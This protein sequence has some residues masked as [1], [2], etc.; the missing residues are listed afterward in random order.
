MTYIWERG[1]QEPLPPQAAEIGLP[2][3][4]RPPK[5]S[6]SVQTCAGFPRARRKVLGSR[7]PAPAS[8]GRRRPPV[9]APGVITVPASRACTDS[10]RTTRA[11]ESSLQFQRLSR[12]SPAFVSGSPQARWSKGRANSFPGG[13]PLTGAGTRA[14]GAAQAR[15]LSPARRTRGAARPSGIAPHPGAGLA[16]GG[17]PAQRPSSRA[18]R[19]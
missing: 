11:P 7:S 4:P 13:R 15:A 9:R 1:P 5:R 17:A 8:A 14:E 19:R 12:P 10:C 16:G 6:E 18:P 3:P 2:R